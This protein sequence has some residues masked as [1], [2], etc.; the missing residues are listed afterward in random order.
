MRDIVAA[1]AGMAV[2]GFETYEVPV[3]EVLAG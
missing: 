3:C 1:A 2:V